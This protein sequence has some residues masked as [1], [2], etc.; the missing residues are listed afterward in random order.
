MTAVPQDCRQLRLIDW[1]SGPSGALVG[2][3][4]VEIAGLVINDVAIFQKDGARWAQLPSEPMRDR[5][6][7]VL[8]D[9]RGKTR[10]RSAIKW[11]TRELQERFSAALIAAMET[12]YG[13][14]GGQT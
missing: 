13:G 2:R 5:G 11:K 6:G 3:A 12:R 9:G 1:K 7:Q 10:Y 4:A 14:L 8:K